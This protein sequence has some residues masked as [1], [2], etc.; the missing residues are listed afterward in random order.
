MTTITLKNI[1]DELHQR[2]KERASRHHRSLNSEI[3]A[4][5]EAILR[6]EPL[7]PKAYIARIRK[8]R[9]PGHERLTEE[10]FDALKDER[11]P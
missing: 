11:R 5:L 8:L 7:D 2:L 3:L 4:S 1:P 9:P 10:D 6:S